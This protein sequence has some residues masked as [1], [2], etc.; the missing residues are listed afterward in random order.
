VSES[1]G[2]DLKSLFDEKGLFAIYRISP[3]FRSNACNV[4]IAATTF[5]ILVATSVLHIG[6]PRLRDSFI[7][8]FSDTFTSLANGGLALAGTIL[9]FLIAGFAIL[10]TILRP[11]TMLA[12][13]QIPNEKY[14]LTELKLLFVGFVDVMVQF[15]ALLGWSA[16]VLIV[17]GKTG[18]AAMYGA[19]LARI[20]WMIPYVLLHVVLVLWGTWLLM[21]V[22]ALKSF[23]FNLYHSL[24]LGLADAAD[25][26]QR[27]KRKEEHIN[28]DK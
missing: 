28:A 14:K 1:N 22:L 25:D 16:I 17:G 27:Q 7:F 9:G 12:L 21:L 26:Y 3:P 2:V 10:C 20:H 5:V 23:I 13:H 11:Q 4:W 19:M 18:M 8:P 24:L 6:V 15:L